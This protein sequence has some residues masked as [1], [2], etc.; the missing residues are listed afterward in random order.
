MDVPF[1]VVCAVHGFAWECRVFVGNAEDGVEHVVTVSRAELT[2]YAPGTFEPTPLV[3]ASFRFLL[4]REPPS[5]IL[6]KFALSEIERY[7]PDYPL[8]IG[9]YLAQPED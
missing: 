6:R 8:V 1:E 2:R 9:G 7:F 3:E 4:E 5:A